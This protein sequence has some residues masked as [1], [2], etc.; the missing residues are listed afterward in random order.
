MLCPVYGCNRTADPFPR[1]DK[2]REH[3]GRKHKDLD[4][5][6]CLIETCRIGPLTRLQLKDHLE[7]RHL[8]DFST[9]SHFGDYI[10]ALP[11]LG[12]KLHDLQTRSSAA[13]NIVL[14][15]RSRGKDICPLENLGCRFRLSQ[16]EPFM[17]DHL[18]KH[19]LKDL[20]EAHDEVGSIHPM[21]DLDRIQLICP[22][23]HQDASRN[24]VARLLHH[25]L[26]DHY[27][28]Q[29]LRAA[30]QSAVNGVFRNGVYELACP[31]RECLHGCYHPECF[32]SFERQ[33]FKELLEI[34]DRK[35]H[36]LP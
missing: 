13:L 6:L 2:F 31:H 35:A 29:R 8:H 33:S 11:S 7:N 36:H 12:I 20:F 26:I 27:K 14:K 18:K 10:A 23:C 25:V 19:D 9:Q 3:V 24:G 16:N 21:W 28:Q 15:Q 34:T 4:K 1:L 32:V 22:I 30:S 17:E 5:F